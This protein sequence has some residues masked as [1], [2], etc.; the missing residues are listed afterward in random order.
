MFLQL[1]RLGM[2]T[3]SEASLPEH[4][5]WDSIEALSKRQGLF[6][7]VLDGVEKLPH[8]LRPPLTTWLRW[9]GEVQLEEE[10]YNYQWNEACKMAL[11]F[12]QNNIRTY[13]LKGN[14]VSECYPKPQ[15]RV[16]AD[17]DS[18]LVNENQNENEKDVWE[19]GNQLIE[20]AGYEVEKVFYKNSTFRLPGLTVENHRFL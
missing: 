17:F 10:R 16:S 18:F 4:T 15:H 11:Q 19:K 13:V 6:A 9:I 12:H 3:S 8:S 14:V 2:G 1:A 5:D 7:V 20:E